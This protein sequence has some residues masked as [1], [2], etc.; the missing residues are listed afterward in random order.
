MKN[1]FI[2]AMFIF[3]GF[4]VSVISAGYIVRQNRLVLE[5]T[6]KT[7]TDSLQ[8]I[9]GMSS[10]GGTTE[11]VSSS[12][13]SIVNATTNT[14]PTTFTTPIKVVAKPVVTN[15][16]TIV[17]TPT[18]IVTP[19]AEP[20]PVIVPTGPTL[21]TVATHNTQ[22]DCWVILHDKVYSVTSYI[23]MHPGGAQRIVSVCGSDATS[24]F[25]GIKRGRG[26]SSYAVSLLGQYLV[27][28]L[29]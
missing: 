17:I 23:P 1:T 4:V 24:L 27:G 28:T 14:K 19:V 8:Q 6:Q 13:V 15:P 22:S 12:S 11:I 7:Y 9:T 20:K 10:K 26:H 29:Q 21:A 5:A 3:W 16:G 2:V 25:E 18:P